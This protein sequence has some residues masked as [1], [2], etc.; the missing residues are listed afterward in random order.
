M[1][2]GETTREQD[3][4]LRQLAAE[5]GARAFFPVV[6]EELAGVYADITNQLANQYSLGYESSNERVDG[7]LRRIELRVVA[8]GVTWRTRAG[9]IASDDAAVPGAHLR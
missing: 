1:I 4:E 7:R 2:F 3:F 9:H 6:L 8:P 5:T